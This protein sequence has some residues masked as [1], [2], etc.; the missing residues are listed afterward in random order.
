MA[1]FSKELS[2]ILRHDTKGLK[3]TE[4][5]YISVDDILSHL[6]CTMEELEFE[7]ENNDKKRFSFSSDKKLIRANQGHS[8]PI[9]IN[10]TKITE[11]TLVLYHGTSL[12]NLDSIKENGLLPM[13]RIHVHLTNDLET[14]KTVGLRY[15]KRNHS[16]LLF[17]INAKDL[18]EN[19]I[20]IFKS[21]NG[22]YLTDKIPYKFLNKI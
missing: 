5:G 20:E 4:C 2:Y 15:A 12:A 14:A 13:N 1:E 6:N 9:K 7:I 21:E 10:Y 18:I 17:Q 22:V 3:M 11:K 19:G 16:L 8:L